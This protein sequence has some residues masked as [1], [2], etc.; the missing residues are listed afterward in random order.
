LQENQKKSFLSLSFHKYFQQ[1]TLTEKERMITVDL[2][3]LTLLLL[4]V[5]TLFTIYK[6]SNLNEEVN[7]TEPSPS[8]RVLCFSQFS[9]STHLSKEKALQLR[10]LSFELFG[11][12]L[13]CFYWQ[14]LSA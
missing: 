2:L 7:C 10:F 3:V 1:G 4:I 12:K 11:N 8:V 14:I 6:A 5:Q 9:F 13:E